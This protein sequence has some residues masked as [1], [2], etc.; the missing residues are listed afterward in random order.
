MLTIL[1]WE[2]P[3]GTGNVFLGELESGDFWEVSA[4]LLEPQPGILSV[5]FWEFGCGSEGKVGIRL[6]EG[7][8]KE[9]EKALEVEMDGQ[10]R[11]C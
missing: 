6:R 7:K 2:K 3:P 4:G 1:P 10:E 11:E 8:E 9:Q 5:F